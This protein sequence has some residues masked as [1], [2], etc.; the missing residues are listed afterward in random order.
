MPALRRALATPPTKRSLATRPYDT[1]GTDTCL[2]RAH[3][4]CFTPVVSSEIWTSVLARDAVVSLGP[5]DR[6]KIGLRRDR[7]SRGAFV[8][9]RHRKKATI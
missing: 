1:H 8:W 2:C 4:S 9:T 7:S 3:I 6:V 5:C